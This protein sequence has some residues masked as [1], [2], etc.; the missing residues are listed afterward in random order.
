[1]KIPFDNNQ[2]HRLRGKLAQGYLILVW[3]V[4]PILVLID[5]LIGLF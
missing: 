1:M 2:S 3:I 5:A 4:F